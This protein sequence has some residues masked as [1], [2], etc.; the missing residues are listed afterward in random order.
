[1]PA[2][3]VL[4]RPQKRSAG[5]TSRQL[6][7]YIVLE[8]KWSNWD[9]SASLMGRGRTLN[10]TCSWLHFLPRIQS[11]QWKEMEN[12]HVGTGHNT[13]H[14]S[15]PRAVLRQETKHLIRDCQSLLTSIVPESPK[16]P[17]SAFAE[18]RKAPH[19][20]KVAPGASSL[21]WA[22]I[23][24]GLVTRVCPALAPHHSCQGARST[25]RCLGQ[26]LSCP[27]QCEPSCPSQKWPL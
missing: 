11:R 3:S 6:L 14:S 26:A 16:A 2:L 23:N 22:R 24:N 9:R 12:A 20:C 13:T 1:M 27:L 10:I 25:Q 7:P 18:A 21:T 4:E 19:V 17:G 15:S 8:T 5:H